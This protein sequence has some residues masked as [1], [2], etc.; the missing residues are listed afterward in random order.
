M[1]QHSSSSEDHLRGEGGQVF[2]CKAMFWG[3]SRN[4]PSLFLGDFSGREINSEKSQS[5][6]SLHDI[7]N[8][9]LSFPISIFTMSPRESQPSHQIPQWVAWSCTLFSRTPR[10][11]IRHSPGSSDAGAHIAPL[12][13]LFLSW[14]FLSMACLFL[15][16]TMHHVT[17]FKSPEISLQQNRQNYFVVVVVR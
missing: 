5:A 4:R 13:S 7:L 17:L 8:S 14:K 12:W 10:C 2:L 3:C 6:G 11:S 16:P 15:L 1:P 9:M